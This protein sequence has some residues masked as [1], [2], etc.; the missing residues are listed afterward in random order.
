MICLRSDKARVRFVEPYLIEISYLDKR[1][2]IYSRSCK[3][4]DVE[5]DSVFRLEAQTNEVIPSF[6]TL[7]KFDEERISEI[8]ACFMLDENYVLNLHSD[9]SKFIS[10]LSV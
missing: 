9:Q 10:D 1:D 2:P 6:T 7:A 5:S 8:V 4:V 3:Y